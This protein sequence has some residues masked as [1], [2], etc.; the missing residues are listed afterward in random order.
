MTLHYHTCGHSI[1][2]LEITNHWGMYPTFFDGADPQHSTPIT[3]CPRCAQ[4]LTVD[5]LNEQPLSLAATL[6]AWQEAWPDLQRRIETLV[7]HHV[8]QNPHFY[9]YHVDVAVAE[10][11]RALNAMVE[12]TAQLEAQPAGVAETGR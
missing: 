1:R 6:A 5:T 2:K 9:P 7:Q 3:V 4:P 11:A 10:F 8:E 12:I